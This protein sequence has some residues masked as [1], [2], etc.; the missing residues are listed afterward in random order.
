MLCIKKL[1]HGQATAKD[2]LMWDSQPASL[3]GGVESGV[4]A[5][6][7]ELSYVQGKKASA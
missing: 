5:G 2:L 7:K 6:D 1:D 3:W 4:T